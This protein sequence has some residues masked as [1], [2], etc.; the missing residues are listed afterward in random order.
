MEVILIQEV[1]K[2]GQ[3]GD[4]VKVKDGYARNFLFP[5]GL[6]VS[7]DRAHKAQAAALQKARLRQVEAEK[8]KAEEIAGRI[9]KAACTIPVSV[10]EQDKLH[11]AVTAADIAARLAQQGISI[12]KHQIVLD[13][14]LTSLGEHQV[15]VKLHPAVTVNVT[16]SVVRK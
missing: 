13:G 14:P 2:L 8:A 5:K 10:G 7:A 4:S 12:D 6:A 11:G 3:A 1:Q 16:V 9:G 15:S